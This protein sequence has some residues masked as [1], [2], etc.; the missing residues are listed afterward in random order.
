[1]ATTTR[2]DNLS[3]LPREAARK[4]G[5]RE[6][7]LF[8]DKRWT[9]GE[10]DAEVDRIAAALI[11]SGMQPGEH[12]ALYLP[13]RPEF[14]FLYFSVIRAGGVAVPLNTRY[15]RLDLAYALRQCRAGTLVTAAF[16]GPVALGE[17]V[18]EV[19][20]ADWLP[21]RAADVESEFPDLERIVSLEGQIPLAGAIDWTSFLNGGRS[22]SA[23]EI[24]ARE[25]AI[26][27]AG[28]AVIMY[29]SGTTSDPKGVMLGHAAVRLW[30]DRSAMMGMTV[31]DV[32]LNY[33]P[34]FHAYSLAYCIGH[35]LVTGGRQ[36]LTETFDP[37]EALALVETEAVS[38]IHGFDTHFKSFLTLID[39]KPYNLTSLRVGSFA[40]GLENCIDIAR[41]VQAR[42]CPTLGCFGMTETWSGISQT[43]LDGTE[44][45]RCEASGYPL[46]GVEIR[47]VD[48]ETAADAPTGASGEIWIKSYSL[49]L[50]YYD[51][52]QQTAEVLDSD[53][54]LHTGDAGLLRP[55]GHLRFLGRLKDM[56]KVGGENVSPAEIEQFLLLLPEIAEV[57][58][59]GMPDDRLA[60]VPVAFVRLVRGTSIQENEIIDHCRGKL[61][62]F[63]APRRIRFVEEL[64][65][66]ASG[67]IQ[68]AKLRALIL[69]EIARSDAA[70]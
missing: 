19:V 47:I 37:E 8:G 62:S 46:P 59:V 22:I 52:P 51:L 63:K 57:A 40:T 9:Y 49:M 39:Q 60:E 61:A 5:E 23:A 58:V 16:A 20:G 53:G 13:N 12:V 7:L 6:A 36:V 26:D 28:C 3:L 41:A 2:P 33:L 32:Q 27:P 1:M 25:S 54:W 11:A 24:A 29:T 30:T 64:P 50:G 38:I 21:G 69:E 14:I 68:K 48:P 70:A 45:Q 67:K 34:L 65:A 66:T 56:L 35:S 18:S 15:R 4:W 43:A 17:I 31:H 55:D 42:I 44:E 10:F